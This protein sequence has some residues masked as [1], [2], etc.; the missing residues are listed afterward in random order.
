MQ[1]NHIFD[2]LRSYSEKFGVLLEGLSKQDSE[3]E[4]GYSEREVILK[5]NKLTL[6]HYLAPSKKIEKKH[7]KM[8]KKYNLTINKQTE[9]HTN[10][11]N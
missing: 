1:T 10:I 2:E 3:F 8:K 7:L 4:D 9:K 5:K 11:I 6:Y